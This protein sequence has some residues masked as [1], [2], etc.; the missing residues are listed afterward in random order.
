LIELI[1]L[2][3]LENNHAANSISPGPIFNGSPSNSLCRYIYIYDSKIKQKTSYK[4][5]KNI[6]DLLE[7]A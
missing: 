7:I 6:K 5:Y 2:H 3:N 1:L 4:I